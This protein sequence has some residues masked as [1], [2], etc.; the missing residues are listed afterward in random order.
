MLMRVVLGSIHP[1]PLSG[2]IEGLVGLAEVLQARGHSVHVVSEFPNRDLLS[3]KRAQLASK[4]Q[5]I[6]FDQPARMTR[7]FVRLVRLAPQVDVIQLNL[8]TPAFSIFAL[9]QPGKM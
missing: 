8:P 1:R 5:R 7:I 2:Q 4:P 3:A 6:V 9:E